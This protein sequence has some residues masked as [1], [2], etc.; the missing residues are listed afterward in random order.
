MFLGLWAG[1]GASC[2][3]CALSGSVQQHLEEFG[4]PRVGWS[5]H[6]WNTSRRT[7]LTYLC[8]SAVSA[9]CISPCS[10]LLCSVPPF[11]FPL[12]FSILFPLTCSCGRGSPSPWVEDAEVERTKGRSGAHT[13]VPLDPAGVLWEQ[14]P[15]EQCPLSPPT[16]LRPEQ[17]QEG[18]SI[19]WKQQQIPL[20]PPVQRVLSVSGGLIP[21]PEQCPSACPCPLCPFCPVSPWPTP[22]QVL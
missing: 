2:G 14:C 3:S 22:G 13:G 9:R 19:S 11:S 7:C 21:A 1:T 6:P 10:A 5:V 17:V 8:S 15:Q 20:L 16:M 18:S 12:C 4:Q